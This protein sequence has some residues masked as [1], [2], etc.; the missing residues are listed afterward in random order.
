MRPVRRVAELGSLGGFKRMKQCTLCGNEYPDDA[1]VCAIDQQ[2][3]QVVVSSSDIPSPLP[4]EI[5]KKSDFISLETFLVWAIAIIA[6]AVVLFI[7]VFVIIFHFSRPMHDS[8]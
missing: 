3:L 8:L 4:A 6:V 7:I 1:S 5:R 2:P